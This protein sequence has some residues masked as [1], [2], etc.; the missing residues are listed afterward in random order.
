MNKI[1]DAHITLHTLRPP[2]YSHNPLHAHHSTTQRLTHSLHSHHRKGTTPYTPT[3]PRHKNT[4]YTHH[5]H[6]H[7]KA[8]PSPVP[9]LPHSV[10]GHDPISP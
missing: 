1:S 9:A 5:T 6:H 7:H 8:P 4:L 10:P 2:P 3:I